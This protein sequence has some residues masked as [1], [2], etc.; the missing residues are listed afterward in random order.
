MAITNAELTP[1]LAA[2]GGLIPTAAVASG[3]PTKNPIAQTF[4]WWA[5]TATRT[6][7]TGV[8]DLTPVWLPAGLTITGATIATVGAAG[9]PTHFW[10]A[11]YDDGR[12]T[13]TANQLSL[14]GQSA[15]NTG[16]IAANALISSAFITPIVTQY[17]GIYY[18]AVMG[19]AT[20]PATYAG[21]PALAS[22]ALP[23]FSSVAG[24]VNAQ[25]SILGTAGSAL[26][27]TAPNPTGTITASVAA[28]LWAALF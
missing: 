3:A 14:L 26:T 5:A 16:A 24:V 25:S 21:R 7:S 20:T 2:L 15:D 17:T 11:L 12:G 6:P 18:L 1:L 4:P 9:T 19:A 23:L 10:I 28:G 22:T 27:T 8:M 13:S